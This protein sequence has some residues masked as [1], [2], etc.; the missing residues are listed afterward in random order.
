[1]A[2]YSDFEFITLKVKCRLEQ[3]N[4]RS[5]GLFGYFTQPPPPS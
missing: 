5:L 2:G 4:D 3:L 1:L